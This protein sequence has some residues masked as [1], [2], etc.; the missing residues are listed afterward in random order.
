MLTI[1]FV[2]HYADILLPISTHKYF[3]TGCFCK[4]WY[5][6]FFAQW[7]V[8]VF[9]ASMTYTILS[10]IVE[11]KVQLDRDAPSPEQSYTSKVREVEVMYLI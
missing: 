6:L 10:V 1:T 2:Q 7:K 5:K 4:K 11:S 8:S 3:M 9:A